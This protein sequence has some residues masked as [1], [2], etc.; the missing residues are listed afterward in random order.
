MKTTLLLL[1]ILIGFTS[2]AGSGN[3]DP[4]QKMDTVNQ[5]TA[6]GRKNGYW[7]IFAHMRNE[8][9]FKPDDVIEEGRFKMSRKD[10]MWKKY[11]PSGK[12]R[13]DIVY[14][15]GKAIGN[16]TTY[17]DNE[18]NT[19]EESGTWGG[20][21]Y[22]DTFVRYH[23][24]GQI[25]QQKTFGANGKPQGKQAYFYENGQVELEFEMEDGVETGTATKYWPNGDVKEII[26]FDGEG[27]GTSSGEKVRVN[28]PVILESQKDDDKAGNGVE[29]EGEKNKAEGSG[30]VDGYNKTY[31]EN[32]DI[33]MDGE[34]KGGKLIKG[35]HYIYDEY[36]LLDK[37][38]M[39]ENG[40]YIGN[41]VIE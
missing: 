14:K 21:V 37:I 12:K 6:D 41:G 11:F 40:K 30:I 29:G 2:Y 32:K 34:F 35:K 33:L 7:M 23:A 4:E 26:T 8:P 10:G 25:A 5:K 17:Y 1:S 3:I 27:A 24:N 39:Y 22:K 16:F 18:E 31:N 15:N 36:G 28:P 20:K 38:K 19:A 9:N 13:S